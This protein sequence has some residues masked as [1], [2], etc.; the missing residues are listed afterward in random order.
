M[1]RV[2]EFVRAPGGGTHAGICDVDCD[3]T[4][5]EHRKLRRIT[6][7]HGSAGPLI[8]YSVLVA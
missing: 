1:R 8:T 3:V 2:N 4:P 6:E 5:A 7:C